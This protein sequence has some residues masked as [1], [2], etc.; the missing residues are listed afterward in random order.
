MLCVLILYMSVENYSLKSTRHND[1][2]IE[3]VKKIIL[4]NR[5]ITIGEV[6]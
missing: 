1:E 6:A 3:T 5:R 4:N 2:N